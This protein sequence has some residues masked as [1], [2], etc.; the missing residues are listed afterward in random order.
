MA[1]PRDTLSI[2]GSQLA[3]KPHPPM[4][5]RI[6]D[7]LMQRNRDL[8]SASRLEV[9]VHQDKKRTKLEHTVWERSVIRAYPRTQ[10]LPLFRI[11][12]PPFP[13]NPVI[14]IL[15]RNSRLLPETAGTFEILILRN[16]DNVYLE[17]VELD[18]K[19]LVITN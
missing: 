14:N 15:K 19:Q 4:Y 1:R 10:N 18:T 13:Q 2:E 7:T 6:S 12:W 8:D 16:I 5:G 17:R 3:I 11:F 9:T